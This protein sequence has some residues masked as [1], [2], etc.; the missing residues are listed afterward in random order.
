METVSSSS[1]TVS[2]AMAESSTVSTSQHQEQVPVL[3]NGQ[4]SHPPFEMPDPL[5]VYKQTVR[6]ITEHF[7]FRLP[8][9]PFFLSPPLWSLLSPR[10]E[11]R[12]VIQPQGL[13]PQ[14]SRIV[15]FF[16]FFLFISIRLFFSFRSSLEWKEEETISSS[17]Q[18]RRDVLYMAMMSPCKSVVCG[19]A[20]LVHGPEL[21]E[22][23]QRVTLHFRLDPGHAKNPSQFDNGG[24]KRDN[25]NFSKGKKMGGCS[26][27]YPQ[28]ANWLFWFSKSASCA[29]VLFDERERV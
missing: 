14:S 22:V 5:D 7:L 9:I 4:R 21:M 23:K 15:L 20:G 27:Q 26:C 29:K 13:E 28:A 8:V 24:V 2:V 17:R 3:L 11:C 1:S 10:L 16:F 19:K 12:K 25:N 6:I 18:L